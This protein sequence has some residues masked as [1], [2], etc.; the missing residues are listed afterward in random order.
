ME[1]EAGSALRGSLVFTTSSMTM[2]D[3]ADA[4]ILVEVNAYFFLFC[5]CILKYPYYAV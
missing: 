2:D 1:C 5:M 3:T 4:I